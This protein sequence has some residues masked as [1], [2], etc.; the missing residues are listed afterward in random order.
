MSSRQIAIFSSTGFRDRFEAARGSLSDL[1]GRR[2]A[3]CGRDIHRRC[4]R[5]PRSLSFPV[6]NGREHERG[7][8]QVHK[9][10]CSWCSGSGSGNEARRSSDRDGNDLAWEHRRQMRKRH[11]SP[12]PRGWQ[13]PHCH[14]QCRTRCRGY[15]FWQAHSLLNMGRQRLALLVDP[16]FLGVL[17]FEG[18]AQYILGVR[19]GAAGKAF[20]DQC[21]KIGRDEVIA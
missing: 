4:L 7:P 11:R 21:F 1:A 16:G 8:S 17:N 15:R 19:V 5:T 12:I 14:W 20:I 2:D 13:R 9:R 3:Q 6:K 10:P 18:S